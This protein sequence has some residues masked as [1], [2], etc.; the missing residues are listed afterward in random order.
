[1]TNE[2]PVERQRQISGMAGVYY[3]AAELSSLGY[4]VAVTSR[5]ALGADLLV[6]TADL[7]KSFNVQV[8][9][10]RTRGTQAYWLMGDVANIPVSRNL[11]Y[12]FVNM[13][14][15]AKPDFYIVGS[16]EVSKNLEP[17]RSKGKEKYQFRRNARYKDN[18]AVFS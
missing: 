1:M 3:V 9:T 2:S 11:V 10:N 17:Y 16:E 13:K 6:S 7:D 14:K 8:K 5:N 15:D 12:V 18:W 4:I